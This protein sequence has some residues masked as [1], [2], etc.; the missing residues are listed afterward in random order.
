MADTVE[1]Q[2]AKAKLALAAEGNPDASTADIAPMGTMGQIAA[3]MKQ[4]MPIVGTG[5]P[6]EMTTNPEGK[7]RYNTAALAGQNQGDMEDKVYHELVHLAQMRKPAEAQPIGGFPYV[8]DP[9]EIE[10]YQKEHAH[11]VAHGRTPSPGP[12]EQILLARQMQGK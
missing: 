11:A 7:I 5:L 3:F 12:L 9:D 8:Q 4:H 6:V 1:Q 2:I 10:A